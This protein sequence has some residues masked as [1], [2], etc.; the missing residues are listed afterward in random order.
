MSLIIFSLPGLITYFW[1][2]MFGINPVVKHTTTEMVGLTALLWA[3]T[4]LFTV[5]VYDGLFLLLNLI[6]RAL[7]VNL[8][9][10]NLDLILS[11]K[12]LTYLSNNLLFLF[13]YLIL[14][15]I[16]SFTV[17]Y[18]WSKYLYIRVLEIIN[19][20]RIQRK[21]I[22]L[23]EDP[24]VW[25]SFFYRLEEQKEAQLIVEI[26]KI[27]NPVEKICGPVIRMSRPF[28]TEKSLIIDTSKGWDIAHAFYNYEITRS[29]VDTKSG[30]I[31]NELN[32]KKT[33]LKIIT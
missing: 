19:K 2:Q 21:I 13:Y 15:L 11:L 6:F 8:S 5:L 16:F 30:L 23:S 29:Y 25:E 10:L 14:S 31:I 26:Y 9:F 7:K 22:K 17:A 20:V 4:T 24:T 1:L 3:P 32:P 33:S 27:D 12:D 18:I 28:E